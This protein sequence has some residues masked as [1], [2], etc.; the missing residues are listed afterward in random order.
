MS[1]IPTTRNDTPFTCTMAPIGFCEV[2]NSCRRTVSPSTAT[3]P[4][5]RSSSGVIARPAAI[6][7]FVIGG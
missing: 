5:L 4:A 7:Q 1:R 2:P 3:S 6:C